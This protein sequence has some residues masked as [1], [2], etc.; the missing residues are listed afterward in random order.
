[1]DQFDKFYNRALR[2]L[3]FRPRSEKEI[4]DKLKSKKADSKIVE[5][6][7]TKL[8]AQ[9]F[10]N[11][12]EFTKWWIE[13]RS[14]FQPRGLRMIKMELR[15]KGIEQEIIEKII[16]EGIK[17]QESPLRQGFAG[18]ARIMD[19]KERARELVRKKIGKYKGLKQ[20]EVYQKLG[21]F[22]GRRGFDF[23]TIKQV[24][25]EVI[26]SGV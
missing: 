12:E 26:R 21:S 22:L 2:F 9:N 11:D 16:S 15:Q 24:I 6:I 1:M 10:I 7:I 4:R 19:D 18:Q 8:K 17:N 5:S 20:Q 14:S 23:D 13:Q 3:S 25:D